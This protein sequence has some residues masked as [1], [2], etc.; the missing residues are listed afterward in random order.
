MIVLG[1]TFFV[2]QNDTSLDAAIS[3]FN[4]ISTVLQHRASDPKSLYLRDGRMA[5][6]SSILNG[7][8]RVPDVAIPLSRNTP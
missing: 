8:L 3:L 6:P 1:N 4:V 2:S 5:E 7:S